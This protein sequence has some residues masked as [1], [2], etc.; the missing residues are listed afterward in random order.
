MLLRQFQEMVSDTVLLRGV[1]YFREGRIRE[2]QARQIND[3]YWRISA[4]VEGTDAYVVKTRIG[5]VNGRLDVESYCD[6][7]YD[8][9]EFCKHSVA[10]IYKF[11]SE[12]SGLTSPANSKQQ[13]KF[14]NAKGYE[15]LQQLAQNV[16]NP[17]LILTYSIKGLLKLSLSNFRLTFDSPH[18]EKKYLAALFE[19]ATSSNNSTMY[20]SK[21][22][23]QIIDSLVSFDQLI[24]NHLRR[25]YTRK[26]SDSGAIYF[27]KTPEN[28]KFIIS[29]LD[30]REIFM[31]ENGAKLEKGNIIRPRGYITGDESQ[32]HI[33]FDTDELKNSGI[34]SPELKYLITGNILH[35]VD[36]SKM[37]KIPAEMT[38]PV[39]RQGEF[40][41][42]ILPALQENIHVELSP[43]LKSHRLQ[44]INPEIKLHLDYEE[45]S[46]LC[47][48]EIKI[49]DTVV[50]GLDTLKAVDGPYY[51]RSTTGENEWWT[52]N[53]EAIEEF[54][55]SLQENGFIVSG[56]DIIIKNQDEIIRFVFS[57]LK[58][59]P[60][61]WEI[62][63]S[64]SFTAFKVTP[65]VLEPVVEMNPDDGINWFDFKVYYNLG[66]KTYSH[67][68]ILA[69]LRESSTGEKYLQI[70]QEFFLIENTEKTAA[71]SRAKE[72]DGGRQEGRANEFFNLLFYRQM[73]REYGIRIK[74]NRIYNQFEEDLS[75]KNPI[76]SYE[77]PAG[78]NG[79]LRHYQH[80]GFNWLCFLNKY[81]LGGILADDMG[82]GK[83]IQVLTLLKSLPK[84]APSLVVCPR[85]LIY[86]WAAEIEKFYPDTSYLVYHGTPEE[87]ERMLADFPVQEIIIT[88]YD[89]VNRDEKNI[90]KI[91]F[92]YCILDEAQLI[93]NHRTQRSQMIKKV[94]S[95][96][97][98][99]IT[100]TPIENSLDELWSIFDFLIPGYLGTKQ[101]FTTVYGTPI[102]NGDQEVLRL[103][104]QKV[105]PFILRRRKD[106]VL[107]E[108]PEKVIMQQKVFMTK[109][110]EDTYRTILAQ[111]R[112]EVLETVSLKGL[113]RSQITVLA[114]LTKLRQVCNHPRLILPE[115]APDTESGKVEV[116]LELIMEAISEGHKVVV[117]SQFVKML[118]II[119]AKFREIRIAY[120]YLDGST[121]DR[122][123]RINRFNENQD[124]GVF[125]IS[126][127]AGGVG[128][129]LTSADIVI[130]VDPWWNP[131]VENQ[132]T[133]RVHRIGQKNQVMVY[134]LITTGTV[135]EK[136]LQLQKKKQ[137]VFDAV[138]E[139]NE[140]PVKTLTWEELKGLFEP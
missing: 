49:N 103:L 38:I 133:D 78:L 97:R 6:C 91:G 124:I 54:I 96:H 120:E 8:W 114:A 20:Y 88:T 90:S 83:T 115:L 13:E 132:A 116:L 24:L 76:Q 92:S 119:E 137:S 89:I 64:E 101:K 94:K 72:L 4:V 50:N 33:K 30:N 61:D 39:E 87:R 48:P 102:K 105:A 134:K 138:I 131:M 14:R 56:N 32:V 41:F 43:E 104:K 53:R 139:N 17:E 107:T 3:Q 118:K 46:I 25:I 123:E 77:V 10:V 117:F 9:E 60:E 23:N 80:E 59:L 63:K 95:G 12:Q 2:Y 109:L 11:F 75:F 85:S 111:V 40:L 35:Q 1:K 70:G 99:V 130:H 44:V 7:P 62:T 129:N 69:M 126:L 16:S 27:A 58:R 47:Q 100:G 128:I 82:L 45:D 22:T 74:G 21:E 67:Q 52:V 121:R 57:G 93:K 71:I 5:I 55:Q 26:D 84:T 86:N 19:Y 113:E 81:R 42:D 140:S 110:Q 65:A 18:T 122:M 31:E 108:L 51:F 112:E 98:L 135:E 29:I 37:D 127:K 68:E 28:L 136:M 106:E 36:I 73:F 15:A 34:Y 66:G 125:L 79:E